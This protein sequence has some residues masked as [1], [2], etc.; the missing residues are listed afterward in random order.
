[1]YHLPQRQPIRNPNHDYSQPCSYFI[2]IDIRFG[3]CLFGYAKADNQIELNPLGKMAESCWQEIP[4]HFPHILLGKYV[5]M[6]NHLHGIVHLRFKG[7]K[8][9]KE[10]T[11]IDLPIRYDHPADFEPNRFGP[12]KKGSLAVVLNQ[13]KS[14]VTRWANSNQ[15]DSFFEWHEKFF[16][17]A[18]KDKEALFLA[19]KYI[20][21]NPHKWW[22][23][24]GSRDW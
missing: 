14:A 6:P 12:L 9:D 21:M 18:V 15:K 10:C 3:Q 11:A 2:T 17:R 23:K 13:F 19:E 8:Y 1:M 5:I 22:V 16:D 20:E 24:Y 4:V 7:A